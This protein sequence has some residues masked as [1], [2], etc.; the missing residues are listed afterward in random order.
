MSEMIE[1]KT[2]VEVVLTSKGKR[3]ILE[4]FSTS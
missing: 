1:L 3:H 2:N 4:S